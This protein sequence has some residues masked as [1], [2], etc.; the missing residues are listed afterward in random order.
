[1]TGPHTAAGA[2]PVVA[3]ELPRAR[4][5]PRVAAGTR[6]VPAAVAAEAA[7]PGEA[8]V[9]RIAVVTAVIEEVAIIAIETVEGGA[10]APGAEAGA[11]AGPLP[12][13]EDLPTGGE[14]LRRPLTE[15]GTRLPTRLRRSLHLLTIT[16][17]TSTATAGTTRLRSTTAENLPLRTAAGLHL[18]LVEEVPRTVGARGTLTATMDRS[19]PAALEA[20]VTRARRG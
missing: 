4:T 16:R 2:E 14:A 20:A 15:D 8:G 1:M 13:E 6:A 11:A 5:L 19:H 17:T 7:V 18:P 9:H 3:A 12:A 10:A